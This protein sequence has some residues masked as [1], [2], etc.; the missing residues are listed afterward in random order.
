M[1]RAVIAL[2]VALAVSIPALR[3]GVVDAAVIFCLCFG[4]TWGALLLVTN[5]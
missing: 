5:P 3:V 2:V 1:A 4:V